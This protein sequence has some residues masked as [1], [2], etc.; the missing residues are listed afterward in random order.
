M[1]LLDTNVLSAMMDEPLPTPVADWLAGTPLR[2]IYTASICQGEILAGIAILPDGRRRRALETEA[3]RLF[4]ENMAGRIWP[5]D[6]VA[7]E[8]YA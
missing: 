3:R 2:F 6:S 5:F 7:A 4:D 8:A 1:F